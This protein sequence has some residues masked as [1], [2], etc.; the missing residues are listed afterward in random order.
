MKEKENQI[1]A[2]LLE[3]TEK[4]N[5]IYEV[6]DL[7]DE[8]KEKAISKTF[9]K[10]NKHFEESFV[11]LVPNGFA[12]LSMEDVQPTQKSQNRTNTQNKS[13]TKPNSTQNNKTSFSNKD[14]NDPNNTSTTTLSNNNLLSKMIGIKVSFGGNK[15]SLQNMHQLSG[16]QKT[17]VAI[18]LI[19]AL[20]KI[21]P[22][23]FY[24]LDEIDAALDPVLR[25]NLAKM[26]SK[27]SLDNQFI[28]TTFK[29]EILEEANKVYQVKFVNKSSNL[30][31]VD[32]DKGRSLLNEISYVEGKRGKN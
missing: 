16:G 17:A 2:K 4:S 32:K 8:K 15:S 5:S 10:I 24:I 25:T 6:I 22:A 23:P 1:E 12:T 30:V 28:I 21:D 9:I 7:L 27:L 18:I 31:E 20:S 14:N 13:Q 19:F 29:P 3:L 26:I 11:E